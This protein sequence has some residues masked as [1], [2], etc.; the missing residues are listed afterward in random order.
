MANQLTLTNATL[1]TPEG[2]FPGK[3]IEI[4]DGKIID[5]R[6]NSES[7]RG[8]VLPL[9]GLGVSAGWIDIQ[10]NGGFGMDFTV[11]PASIWQVAAELPRYGVTAFLPTIITSPMETFEKAIAVLRQGPPAGWS[12][13][14]PIGLHFEGP[15]LNIGKKGAHPPAY[16][17]QPDL[18]LI[19][20]WTKE[21]GVSLVT[22]APE[23][24][25]A[26]DM[27]RWLRQH[28]VTVSAGHSLATVE[29]A[30]LA[31]EAGVRCGTHLFNAMPTL[32]HRAPGLTGALLTSDEVYTGFICDGVHSHPAMAGLAWRAKGRQ[33]LILVTDA[34]AA[35]GKAPG[36]YDLGD[37]SVLVD[38]TSARLA[39]APQTLAGSILSLDAAVRNI[40][41][42]T[43]CTLADAVNMVTRNPAELLGLEKQRLLAPG[44][45]ADLTVF[46]AQGQVALVLVHGKIIFRDQTLV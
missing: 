42:F 15:F 6:T 7:P 11:D 22:L 14:L 21:N 5:I 44:A 16:L 31:F 24:P 33:R 12:G 29:E 23:L 45:D 2:I 37:H 17:R 27:V 4:L 20:Q 8:T 40:Q 32:D 46:N 25:G 43:G 30:R 38:E 28:H 26:L 39:D 1:Y 18:K 13:A 10:F 3:Q 34:M 9:D 19:S 35:L 36:L 41:S